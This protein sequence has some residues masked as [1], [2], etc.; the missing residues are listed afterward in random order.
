[1][2]HAESPYHN[3]GQVAFG[4]DGLLYVSVGDGGYLRDGAN[5]IPDP[6]GNA[7]N[8]DVLLGKIFTIDIDRRSPRA[9]IVAYGLRNPWRFSFDPPSGDLIIG[10]VGYNSW[11]EIDV[12]E[13]G[14]GLANFG[15]SAYEG[16]QRR[17]ST[18]SGRGRLVPPALTYARAGRNCSVIG[19]YV[20]RGR[21]V[22]TLRGRYV[23]GDYCGGKIWSIRIRGGRAYG[24]RLEPVRVPSLASFGEDGS[25]EL[26]AVS[27][28]G[29]VFRF[30]GR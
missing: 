25:G 6:H 15:W 4:P 3:G 28:E 20:Y 17:S 30:G 18:V 1:V 27:L 2:P 23:F 16:R 8:L 11:E 7:Q 13:A 29:T 26:Y 24:R 14:E 10:D 21:A 12:L 5:L 9:E 19:G 22:P